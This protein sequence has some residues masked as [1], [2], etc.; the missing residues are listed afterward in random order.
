MDFITIIKVCLPVF[1]LVHVEP[2]I[3]FVINFSSNIRESNEVVDFLDIPIFMYL[4]ICGDGG[5][6]DHDFEKFNCFWTIIPRV[7]FLI[8]FGISIE[9]CI[10]LIVFSYFTILSDLLSLFSLLCY[11]MEMPCN[12]IGYSCKLLVSV[13]S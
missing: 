4:K 8:S 5:V 2:S 7:T 12:L 13:I 11:F 3:K 1:Q 9:S 6:L 10:L